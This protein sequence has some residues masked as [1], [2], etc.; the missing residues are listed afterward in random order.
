M[1]LD[2]E[3]ED[4][5]NNEARNGRGI[6][7]FKIVGREAKLIMREA[8][9]AILVVLGRKSRDLK[10]MENGINLM[11]ERGM[12]GNIYGRKGRR[13]AVF[14]YLNNKLMELRKMKISSSLATLV[15][16]IPSNG[17][18]GSNIGSEFTPR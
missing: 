9:G 14:D 18:L 6:D 7:A 11:R 10:R 13:S 15:W 2:D 1:F 3:D 17:G 5:P 16:T 8:A 12:D 4:E